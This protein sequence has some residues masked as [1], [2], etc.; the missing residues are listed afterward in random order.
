MDGHRVLYEVFSALG[1]NMDKTFLYLGVLCI[2]GIV[3]AFTQRNEENLMRIAPLKQK[4][5]DL[6]A[7]TAQ[8]CSSVEKWENNF[9]VYNKQVTFRQDMQ[10]AEQKEI[11]IIINK[12]TEAI[13]QFYDS[14]D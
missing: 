1:L 11:R 8:L 6:E 7:L 10:S 3:Y 14:D 12:L 4:V 13:S 2:T 5:K 9:E